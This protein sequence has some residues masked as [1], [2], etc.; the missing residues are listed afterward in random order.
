LG[1]WDDLAVGFTPFID[2][3]LLSLAANPTH[4]YILEIPSSYFLSSLPLEILLA[5]EVAVSLVAS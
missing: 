5:V 2:S 1:D 4:S 3:L